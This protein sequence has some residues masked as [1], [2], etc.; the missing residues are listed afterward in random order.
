MKFLLLL[1]VI[2]GS[3]LL[4]HSQPAG[5]VHGGGIRFLLD[6]YLGALGAC[7][8]EREGVILTGF[9]ERNN[10]VYELFFEEGFA[11]DSLDM[12]KWQLQPWGQGA[13][14]TAQNMDIC[15]LDN[16]RISDGIC[17]II[18]KKETVLRRA[19]N[20]LGDDE[21]LADGLKNLRTYNYTSSNIWSVDKFLYGKYEIRCRLP[22]GNGLWPAFWMFGRERWNEIDVFDGYAGTKELVTSIGHDFEGTKTANGCNHSNKNYDLSEWHTYTCIVEYDRIML[23]IDDTPVREVYRVITMTRKPVLCGDAI[24]AGTY[25]QLKAFPI[26]PMH[27]IVSMGLIS[28]NNGPA[29]SAPVDAS[30]P[31]PSSF[32]VDYVRIWK[33]IPAELQAHPNPTSGRVYLRSNAPIISVGITDINGRKIENPGISPANTEIDLSHQPDGVY[34]LSVDMDGF[35]KRL[36][37]IKMGS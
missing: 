23:L 17:H 22:K 19:V 20:W 4:L 25:F 2:P 24:D 5:C 27:V 13:L 12:K 16:I 36:K 37:V 18:A 3:S 11:G 8:C 7:N 1:V 31:F 14:Q 28:D 6:A 29:G 26:E 32:D 33:K 30:T 21:I 15:T 35:Y 34:I 9:P 10:G